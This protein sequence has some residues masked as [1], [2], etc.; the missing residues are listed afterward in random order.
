MQPDYFQQYCQLKQQGLR[1]EARKPL[2]AFIDSFQS[3]EE[4]IVW[5]QEY[6][7]I[8]EQEND[9]KIRHELY[10]EI[11]FPALL[12]RYRQQELWSIKGLLTTIQNL[13][14]CPQ[15]WEQIDRKTDWMLLEEARALA[16]DDMEIKHQL[17]EKHLK[18]FEHCQ[19][20]WPWGIL[21][22]NNGA[23]VEECE[24]ILRAV[25]RTRVLD[26]ELIHQTFLDEFV[27]KVYTYQRRLLTKS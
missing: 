8:W 27:D 6:L 2:L 17:I 21:Y 10:S 24:E 12:H 25:E 1:K 4:K 22:W 26:C 14:S 3:M 5:T 9:H 13:Y 20:E 11:V 16:P 15:L 23:S 7:P 18:W 19:H